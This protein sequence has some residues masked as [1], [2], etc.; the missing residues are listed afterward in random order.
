MTTC[1][2]LCCKANATT[3]LSLLGRILLSKTFRWKTLIAAILTKTIFPPQKKPLSTFLQSI[4]PVGFTASHIMEVTERTKSG[5][6]DQIVSVVFN[7][8]D[9]SSSALLNR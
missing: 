3:Q 5:L 1:S 9:V 6:K 7:S 2:T 4:L 8:I